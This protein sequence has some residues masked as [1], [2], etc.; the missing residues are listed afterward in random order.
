MERGNDFSDFSRLSFPV[1]DL[2]DA[3]GGGPGRDRSRSVGRSGGAHVENLTAGSFA[4]GSLKAR[5]CH[6]PQM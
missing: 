2:V 3:Q 6:T 5:N 4:E 1:L